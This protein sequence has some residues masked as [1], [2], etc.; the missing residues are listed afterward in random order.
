MRKH[1]LDDEQDTIIKGKFSVDEIFGEDLTYKNGKL[2]LKVRLERFWYGLLDKRDEHRYRRQRA[3][4]GYS[5][6]DV[7][8]IKM[9]FVQTLRPMLEN[10]NAN[11]YTYPEEITF[12]EW[13]SIIEEMILLLRI[14][15]WDDEAFI[16]EYLGLGAE[17][18]DS[19]TRNLVEEERQKASSRFM[20]LFSK[21]FYD[22]RY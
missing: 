19:N 18:F 2:R 6:Y 3:K 20:E 22:L 1:I 7:W 17:D 11:L 21:W 4:R 13:K 9:W 8:N 10:I 5:D 12:E 16:R 15:D 14:M